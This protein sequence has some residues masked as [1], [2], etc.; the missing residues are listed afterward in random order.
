MAGQ[1]RSNFP[2]GTED[3]IDYLNT[4]VNNQLNIFNIPSSRHSSSGGSAPGSPASS[5]GGTRPGQSATQSTHFGPGYQDH[6]PSFPAPSATSGDN[7]YLPTRS[8]DNATSNDS[9]IRSTASLF[10]NQNL[11][12]AEGIERGSV[13]DNTGVLWCPSC[14][15]GLVQ[16]SPTESVHS[17]QSAGQ[18]VG[19]GYSGHNSQGTSTTGSYDSSPTQH[20]HSYPQQYAPH[21]DH[22]HSSGLEYRNQA[23]AHHYYILGNDG[24][25][26]VLAPEVLDD[27]V[28]EPSLQASSQTSSPRSRVSPPI[29]SIAS[30]STSSTPATTLSILPP[31]SIQP[32]PPTDAEMYLRRQ[33]GLPHDKPV[34]LWALR[35]PPNRKKPGQPLPTLMKLAIFGSPKKKLTLQEIYNALI[36]RFEFFK[37]NENELAWKVCSFVHIYN[38]IRLTE[39]CHLAIH[40]RIPSA[41]IFPSTKSSSTVLGQSLTLAKALTGA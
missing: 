41:T 13:R 8:G 22:D 37:D 24:Y 34:D 4:G 6:G 39:F 23:P 21:D 28:R 11:L 26:G 30:S 15:N 40:H 33:I 35:D 31:Q 3:Y 29:F 20:H 36:D 18:S 32:P 9:T 1:P 14:F 17:E 19:S 27:D 25:Q 10:V 5:H 16:G 7:F 38:P 2:I 12:S